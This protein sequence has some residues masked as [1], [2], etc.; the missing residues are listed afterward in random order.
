MSKFAVRALANAIRSELRVSGITVT[1]IS[2]GFVV[3]DI[4]RVDNQGKLHAAAQDPIPAWLAVST[5]TAARHILR[6]VARGKREAIV[7][8]HGKVMVSVERFA[9]WVIRAVGKRL[10]AEGRGYRSEPTSG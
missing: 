9:P 4:R 6:A 2:P 10:A 3:S 8:G 5:E 7:T 1:L